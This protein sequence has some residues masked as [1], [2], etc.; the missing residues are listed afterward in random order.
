MSAMSP[1]AFRPHL[2]AS[3]PYS[4]I[5]LPKKCKNSAQRLFFS[6]TQAVAGK[7]RL[8]HGSRIALRQMLPLLRGLCHAGETQDARKQHRRRAPKARTSRHTFFLRARTLEIAKSVRTALLRPHR[9]ASAQSGGGGN[10]E[11]TQAKL[12]QNC[13]KMVEDVALNRLVCA[14]L[15]GIGK[16]V[17][18]Q[19]DA[20]LCGG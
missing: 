1:E 10:L 9:G 17:N 3:A 11:C 14:P 19:G 7:V 15:R 18:L 8:W 16:A 4:I 5:I 13:Q 12:R 2:P 20:A 6:G